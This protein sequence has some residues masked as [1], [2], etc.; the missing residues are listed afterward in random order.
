MEIKQTLGMSGYQTHLFMALAEAVKAFESTLAA[1]T[2]GPPLNEATA[3]P[4][5]T[6]LHYELEQRRAVVLM[7]ASATVEALANLYMRLRSTP[8]Q[9]LLLERAT[10]VEKWTVVP[11]LFLP[12]Y[13]F[14]TDGELYQDLKRL[15]DRRNALMHL[16][17]DVMSDRAGT[18][19]GKS[20]RYAGDE[21]AFVVRCGTLAR[22]LIEHVASF[23]KSG[24]A[25][26]S[27]MFI[28][29]AEV[30]TGFKGSLTP[31]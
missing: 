1:T 28:G 22:R 13:A 11:S 9:A 29:F 6:I 30:M 26:D 25:K 7:L 10:V 18:H 27:Q 8:E 5:L 19:K 12:N 4:E 14:P 23:D 16:K 2:A 24:A 15:T 17:E 21:H 3:T 31:R 20:P